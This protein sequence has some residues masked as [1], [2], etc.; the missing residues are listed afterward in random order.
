MR[1]RHAIQLLLSTA[2]DDSIRDVLCVA[3]PAPIALT[4]GFF[5]SRVVIGQ[6]LAARL[7][8]PLLDAVVAHERAHS[9]R[10][11]VLRT[12]AASIFALL[13]LP[14]IRRRLLHD[15]SLACEQAAD[16]D[17]ARELSDRLRIVDAILAV[18]RL[19]QDAA[20][21]SPGLATAFGGSHVTARIEHLLVPGT[22]ETRLWRGSLL[23]AA[24]LL[25]LAADPLHHL[26]ETLLTP[27]IR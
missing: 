8:A 26:A 19:S 11:D 1:S 7:P 23:W 2:R 10:R 14:P 4:I 5:R 9:H 3:S 15:L 6:A 22:G 20:V 16:S 17:A 13:H 25:A 12:A 24:G 27:L 21:L 18:E